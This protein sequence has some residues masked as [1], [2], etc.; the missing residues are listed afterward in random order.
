MTSRT[1][2]RKTQLSV[3]AQMKARGQ[4]RT[5]KHQ[6]LPKGPRGFLWNLPCRHQSSILARAL[7]THA[8]KRLIRLLRAD[9]SVCRLRSHVSFSPCLARSSRLC[10]CFK[11]ISEKCCYK[12]LWLVSL[13][14]L[15]HAH[16]NRSDFINWS[17]NTLYAKTLN[18]INRRAS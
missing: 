2:C 8:P 6:I 10:P 5:T 15:I 16:I 18:Q 3:T 17:A 11:N 1:G 13:A 7:G 9:I 12:L 14:S 4:S